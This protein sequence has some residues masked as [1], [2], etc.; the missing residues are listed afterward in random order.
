MGEE[1]GFV[2]GSASG[3]KP[4]G[5]ACPS[6]SSGQE[7]GDASAWSCSTMVSLHRGGSSALKLDV[8]GTVVAKTSAQGGAPHAEGAWVIS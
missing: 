3:G 1:G 6:G 8:A 2:G 7:E 5:S 4:S